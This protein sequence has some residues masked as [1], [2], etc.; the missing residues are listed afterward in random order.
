MKVGRGPNGWECSVTAVDLTKRGQEIFG[1][2]ALVSFCVL[3][4]LFHFLSL[5]LVV[6][7]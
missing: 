6:Y 4:A 2:T 7:Y 5:A 3:P 1:S